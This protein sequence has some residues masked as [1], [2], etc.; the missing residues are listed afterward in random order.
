MQV[1]RFLLGLLIS[2][3]LIT[4]AYTQPS[5]G[6]V[7][8]TLTDDS[9]A[10]IPAVSVTLNGTSGNHTVQS[11][12]DGV[13]TFT[14][15]APGTYSVSVSIPG[16]TPFSQPVTVSAGNIAQ[17]PVQ[18]SVRAEKQEV[19]V[20]AEAGTTITVQPDD[21]QTALVMKGTDLDALPDDPDDLQS[22][23]Q[24]LAGAGAGPN[25]GQIYIDGFSGGQLPP[26]ESIREIRIN[27]NPFSAEYDRL[28][29]G[30]IEILTKPGTDKLR[31]MVMLND[32]NGIFNSRNPFSNNKPDFSTRMW[33]GNLG[34]SI[35]KKASF[36]L[37]FNRRDVQNNAIVV[38]QYFNPQTLTQSNINTA[39]VSPNSFMIIAPRLDYALSTNNTL[40]VRVEE[41]LNNSQNAG[42]GATNLPSP[43]SQL[44]YNSS[45]NAQNVMVT[46]SSILSSKVVNETRFQ[47]YRNWTASNGNELPQI[48]VAGAFVTGGNGLG[49]THDRTKHFELQNNTSVAH[50][51]HTIRFGVRARRDGDQSNQPGG[52]N[53]S[54][55]FLGTANL[56]SLAQYEQ[57]VILSQQGYSEA[58]IQDMGYGPSRFTIQ[59]GQ[60]YISDERYD[61]SP[62]VQDDWRVSPTLTLS[63]G[64]RY[65]IQTLVSDYRDWAPRL[66]FAW[67]PG[68]AR[69]GSPKT[70]IRG[71]FGMFYD[72]IG[73]GLFE[74]AALNNGVNQLQYTIENPTFYP[75]IPALSTLNPGDNTIYR[76]DPKLRADYSM[77]GALGVERQLP[78]NTTVALTYSYNRS[79]HLAQ[80]IPINT[81]LPGTFNPA[82]NLGLSAT[83][84][85]FPYG[86]SAGNIFEDESGGYMRQQLLTFN[87]NTRFNSR[88]SLFGN[89]SLNY[90]K[91][92]PGSPTDP[93]DYRL[94][95]GR[96]TLDRRNNLIILGTIT[97]PAKLRVSPFF[98]VRSGQP[99]DVLAG[100]DL[101]GD[102]L[103]NARAEFASSA[104]CSTVSRSTD[105]GTVCSP[106][107][108]FT[109]SYSV[110]NLANLVPRNYLTMPGLVSVNM[111]VERTF[112]F[113]GKAKNAQTGQPGGG[114]PSAGVMGMAGGG[115][116]GPGG[117]PGGGGPPG[118]GFGGPMGM[119]GGGTEHPYNLT[120]SLNVENVFN[121]L[122]PGGYQGVVTSPY[123][124]EATSVNTGFGG[125]GP[126]GGP[127]GPGGSAANNRRV[128]LGVR[129]NF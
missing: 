85:V 53:G 31:G 73:T 1:R 19:T 129:F 66:G 52:F 42:V 106:Y 34:G 11:Q 15:I 121:H 128:T 70:V 9:G 68:H 22:A 113:G 49:D 79:V 99:Y 29:F 123:F 64:L 120:F 126:G 60:A 72:R 114:M 55:T 25:G 17:V 63:L 27:Q 6:T 103:T 50:G 37:D 7:K 20:A 14:G 16:F 107:G 4:G 105:T 127:G 109:S 3:L 54:F 84:G 104:T 93:Y 67:A 61:V 111:R 10:V 12:S 115:R 81:P 24:A 5:S 97:A 56:T 110:T 43:Y 2:A 80:T 76:V 59:A 38:A 86:Y 100:E 65:E 124:L 35:S 108:T 32:G 51:A 90:A 94:D 75:N 41:R 45:G 47:F 88:I 30:R 87:F 40:T 26:K 119:F 78:R 71:G 33:S 122:N 44:A 83:N 62:F 77:Q 116:G 18:L 112:G 58:E 13:Y 39:V 95:W 21:N 46:E 74:T 57:N 117:G 8:G 28:G 118:G 125:G 92:L 23:L 48:N 96:S 89:Y 69:N 82:S 36:F 98:V 101:Y 102:T 91:D